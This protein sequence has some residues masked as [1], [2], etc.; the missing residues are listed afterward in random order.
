M[1]ARTYTRAGGL[2]WK[3]RILLALGR[4]FCDAYLHSQY[5][6]SYRNPIPLVPRLSIL[7]ALSLSKVPVTLQSTSTKNIK[8][9]VSEVIHILSYALFLLKS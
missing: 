6:P 3:V 7:P 2:S 1:R 9:Q 4:G 8:W 5:E